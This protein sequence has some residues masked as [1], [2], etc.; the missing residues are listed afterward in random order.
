MYQIRAFHSGIIHVPTTGIN[1]DVPINLTKEAR[2]N[3]ANVL[4][5]ALSVEN[6]LAKIIAHYFHPEDAARRN[7]FQEIVVNSDWCSFSA[8]RKLVEW[9]VQKRSLLAGNELG[10]YQK[11]LKDTMSYRNAFAHGEFSA[12]DK[13]VW[14]SFFEGQP[15]KQELSDEYWKKVEQALYEARTATM[16]I[17][18]KLG[19]T[20]MAAASGS[21]GE[22]ETPAG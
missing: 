22:T 10:R 3:K 13:V 19:V 5:G 15:R 6:A 9:I 17:E 4:E 14:L 20:K 8:K 2:R 11:L 18:L 12:D 16:E 1:L 7:E 21:T